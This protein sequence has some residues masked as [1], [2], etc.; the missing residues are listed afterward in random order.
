MHFSK[1]ELNFHY[2]TNSS[3]PTIKQLSKIHLA[4]L[5]NQQ[6]FAN[7]FTQPL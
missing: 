3:W 7:M 2:F 4:L 6:Y 5:F 1:R